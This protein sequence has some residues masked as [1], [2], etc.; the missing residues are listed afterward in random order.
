MAHKVAADLVCAIQSAGIDATFDAEPA[1]LTIA[2]DLS[3]S[4]VI[5]RCQRMATGALRW[6]MRRRIDHIPKL[7]LVARLQQD[8]AS[9]LDYYLMPQ[10]S[11]LKGR[12]TFRGTRR[13]RLQPFR[14][15]DLDALVGALLHHV[16]LNRPQRRWRLAP[17]HNPAPKR[18]APVASCR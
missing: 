4:I 5:V 12:L 15:T 1:R 2:P 11:V 16:D 3:V 6:P 14:M 7:V 18:V 10:K 8:N 17:P 13:A 9:V